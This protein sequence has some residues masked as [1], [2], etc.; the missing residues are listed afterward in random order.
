MYPRRGLDGR[1]EITSSV[2]LGFVFHHHQRP[3]SML[4]RR[5]KEK[6]NSIGNAK[7]T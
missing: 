6:I 7:N 5:G 1:T 2:L 4:G 3:N